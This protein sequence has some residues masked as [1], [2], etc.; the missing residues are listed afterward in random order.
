[1]PKGIYTNNLNYFNDLVNNFYIPETLDVY[2][3]RDYVS[4]GYNIYDLPLKVVWYARVSTNTDDQ[5][6]S[7]HAQAKFFANYLKDKPNWTLVDKYVD[8]GI[9]GTSTKK[10]EDFNR[11]IEDGKNRKFYL[12]LTKEV[13]RFARNTIDSLF[14]T[15]ELLRYGVG[16]YF[17]N[18]GFHTFEKDSELRL[19][20]MSSLAQEESRKISERVKAGHKTSIKSG[21]VLGNN[22]IWG[23]KKVN[24]KLEIV[25][26]EAKIVREIF[27]LYAK[28]F[29]FRAIATKLNEKGYKNS[30]GRPFG[31]SSISGIITN[32]KYKGYYCGGKTT[33]VN[34]LDPSQ[35][36]HLPPEE[37]EMWK[38]DDGDT[39]P[40][41]ISEELWNKCN[42][43][44]TKRSA[45]IAEGIREG[46]QNRYELSGKIICGSCGS[47]YWHNVYKYKDGV[48]K[49]IW[50]CAEYRKFGKKNDNGFGCDN[51]H[52]YSHEVEFILRAILEDFFKNKNIMWDKIQS[53]YESRIQQI[54]YDKEIKKLIASIE[55]I[56]AKKD[57]LLEHNIEGRI[58]DEEFEKRNNEF[59]LQIQA[60]EGQI[61]E[62]EK[63]NDAKRD[64]EATL[65]L[66][67]KF[68]NTEN[69]FSNDR[70]ATLENMVRFL[71]KI[72]VYPTKYEDRIILR[73]I[74][75]SEIEIPSFYKRNQKTYCD[76][77][78]MR[79]SCVTHMTHDKR[80]FKFSRTTNGVKS[81][82]TQLII[83]VETVFD[84]AC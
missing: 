47:S 15:R 29:G 62:Y 67:K 8:E 79:L 12:I 84:L 4:R 25:E 27:E 17:I 52:I 42:E 31:Y 26:E 33:R 59:N 3:I 20:I 65:N 11:M 82:E 10:R 14:Y 64:S 1:M 7:L 36:Q 46:V 9:T 6:H 28:G 57:K 2:T 30:N 37:W 70:K 76:D 34:F 71:D 69:P 53:L 19:T 54:N 77:K 68:L 74:L 43:I 38:D 5:L 48:K 13:S 39:V 81:T 23:Y 66:I 83:E 63:L 73:V 22:N 55:V 72:I 80:I 78:N 21:V 45:I 75:K 44:F 58:S 56:K 18:D 41:I 50:Q 51:P 49:V 40:A 61:Q 60:I 24:G 35:I 32:P 16:V